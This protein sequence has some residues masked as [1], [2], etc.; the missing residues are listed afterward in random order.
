MQHTGDKDFC[1]MLKKLM[2]GNCVASTTGDR[3]DADDL[4]RVVKNKSHLVSVPLERV[5]VSVPFGSV[6]ER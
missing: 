2:A 1:P 5:R 4:A 6:S 3:R